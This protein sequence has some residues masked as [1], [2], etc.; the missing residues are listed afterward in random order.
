MQDYFEKVIDFQFANIVDKYIRKIQISESQFIECIDLVDSSRKLSIDV[1]K[2]IIDY[3]N[4]IET[5]HICELESACVNKCN[6]LKQLHQMMNEYD[7]AKKWYI[8]INFYKYFQSV[9]HD[10]NDAYEAQF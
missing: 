1:I 6:V 10:Y 5:T 7:N 3:R 8:D 2:K 9:I 4:S